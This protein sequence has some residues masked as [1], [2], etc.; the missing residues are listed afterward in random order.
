MSSSSPSAVPV[1]QH[2]EA[3]TAACASTG[4]AP[5][6]APFAA[7]LADRVA[8]PPRAPAALTARERTRAAGMAAV[9]AW[10]SARLLRGL[11]A[12]PA[13][14]PSPDEFVLLLWVHRRPG[15]SKSEAFGY[16]G[17]GATT[18]GQML[19]RLVGRGWLAETS[20]PSDGRRAQLALT[21]AGQAAFA[22][23]ATRFDVAAAALVAPLAGPELRQLEQ[24][25][26][27][28]LA[29]YTQLVDE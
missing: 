25:L 5:A 24:L 20:D 29:D 17:L 27:T 22:A 11:Y 14:G 6:L 21:A 19:A 1:L 7:W 16:A 18:G 12:A 15:G 13:G 8:V 3:Y 4:R 9:Q 10:R 28:V 26:G 2:W 23:A